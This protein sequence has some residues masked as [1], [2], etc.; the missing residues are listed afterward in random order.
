MT[1]TQEILE[2][3]GWVC[4]YCGK[5][6]V[7]RDHVYPG[8]FRR[9]LKEAGIDREALENQ[10]A[11]CRACNEAKGDAAFIPPS[12]RYTVEEMNKLTKLPSWKT[13]RVYRGGKTEAMF[14]K[15]ALL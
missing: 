11:C 3:D 10:V 8:R 13:W 9:V 12:W 4:A 15:E 7:Q 1:P 6:A 14:R 5:R 2:R